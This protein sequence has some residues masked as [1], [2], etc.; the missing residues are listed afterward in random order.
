MERLFRLII[1][2]TYTLEQ[3][4]ELLEASGIEILYGSEE[5]NQAE[6][7]ANLPS[8]GSVSQFHWIESCSPYTLPAIDWEQQW[9]E[10]GFNYHDG[11][12][13][14]D[15][16]VYGRA[17]SSLRLKPGAGFGDMSH[18]TT[19]LMLQFLAKYLKNQVVIDIGCGSGIL[20]LAAVAMGSPYAYGIDIDPNAL[21][22]SK[23]NALLNEM[24][25]RC[26]FGNPI[27]FNQQHLPISPLI[28]M[29]MIQS[30]QK[31]A[32]D[33]LPSLHSCQG[34][35]ITSGIRQEERD[36]YLALTKQW[37]WTLLNEHQ[38]EGWLV[39]YFN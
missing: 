27:E 15:F 24:D 10:H 25:N 34:F 39:F 37:G 21:E 9:A 22:H 32:W 1:H 3:A 13:H 26:K 11:H 30:E 17:E 18:P 7:Y 12:V 14:L 38:E 16:A 20:T 2:P 36:E 8:T 5:E 4:W 31:A 33:S 28:L 23:Q 29:N 35:W 6:I 19:R